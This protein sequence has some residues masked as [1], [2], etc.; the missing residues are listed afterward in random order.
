MTVKSEVLVNRMKEG[1]D[2]LSKQILNLKVE[3][4]ALKVKES[5]LTK[6]LANQKTQP[7]EDLLTIKASIIE[8]RRI[9]SI[10]A[11]ELFKNSLEFTKEYVNG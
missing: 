5:A 10:E 8:D 6:Q 2:N 4:A 3:I 7:E 9:A 11:V 1:A